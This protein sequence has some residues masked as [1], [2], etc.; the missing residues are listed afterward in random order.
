MG[1]SQ[2]LTMNHNYLAHTIATSIGV[3]QI[4][5]TYNIC[6]YKTYVGQYTFSE[7]VERDS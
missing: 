4:R 2:K 5:G 6:D 7:T 3:R 1:L